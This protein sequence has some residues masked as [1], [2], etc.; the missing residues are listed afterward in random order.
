MHTNLE[1]DSSYWNV[2]I[3]TIFASGCNYHVEARLMTSTNASYPMDRRRGFVTSETSSA[4]NV[5]EFHYR[6]DVV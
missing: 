6:A 2:S 3:C 5:I 1:F 4:R